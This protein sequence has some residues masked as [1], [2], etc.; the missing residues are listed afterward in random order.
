M[1]F[2]I[3]NILDY[4]TFLAIDIW[5]FKIKVLVCKIDWQEL[6]IIWSS[7]LRQSKKDMYNGEITD[8]SSISRSIQKAITKA[9]QNLDSIPTDALVLL[10]SSELIYDFT[11]INYVRKW[12]SSPISMKEIDEM[13]EDVE[14]RSL[15]KIKTKTESRLWIIE[16]EMK[17]VT[18]SITGIYVDWQRISNPIWFTWKNIKFNLINVFSPVTRFM[19]LKNIIHDLWLNLISIV[20][21]PISLPKLTEDS[22]YNYDANIYIDFWYSKTTVILQTNSEILWFNVLNFWYSLLEDELRSHLDKGYLD[23]EN[24]LNS[25]DEKYEEYKVIID[26][27][28][29]FIFDS[30]IIAIQDIE[31]SFFAKNVF[32]SWAWISKVLKK[33]IAEHFEKSHIGKNITVIDEFLSDES[34]KEYNA[35]W[36]LWVLSLAKAW[37]ELMAI[38]KDPLVRILRYVLYKYE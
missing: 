28:L 32:V 17:L 10:N 1:S 26:W 19:I 24:I 15:D 27:A 29:D 6:K 9:C 5:A 33:Q 13:I 11:S 36:M 35:N 20:P 2:R 31:K 7:T 21:L 38:K 25:L 8:I 30:L 34:L 16:A 3:S 4:D 23:I 12:N 37:K 14:M 22:P 18:T